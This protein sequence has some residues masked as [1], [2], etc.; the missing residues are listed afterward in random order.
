MG[1]EGGG[2]GVEDILLILF[3]FNCLKPVK[4]FAILFYKKGFIN[5]VGF[6]SGLQPASSGLWQNSNILNFLF[7][8][9]VSKGPT[10]SKNLVL[11]KI[12]GMIH[13]FFL[14]SCDPH[15]V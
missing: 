11:Q 14:S 6:D 10:N 3:Y 8:F 5:K 9:V 7:C 4:H 12:K 1:T 15:F 13:P 2:G